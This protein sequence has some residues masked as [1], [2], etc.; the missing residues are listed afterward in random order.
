MLSLLTTVESLSGLT[1]SRK[2]SLPATEAVFQQIQS[3]T[4]GRCH[5]RLSRVGTGLARG[6]TWHRPAWHRDSVGRCL[7]CP[8]R[9]FWGLMEPAR[10]TR[11]RPRCCQSWGCWGLPSACGCSSQGRA[12]ALG[13]GHPPS[14]GQGWPQGLCCPPAWSSPRPRGWLVA[15]WP[16]GVSVAELLSQPRA[17]LC[18][19][20]ALLLQPL[21]P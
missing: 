2:H 6:R 13:T 9:L 1:Q 19:G 12:M 15:P 11:V 18:P 20:P 4:A 17:T 14:R 21:L 5:M 10:G 8:K 3:V 16:L 7:C